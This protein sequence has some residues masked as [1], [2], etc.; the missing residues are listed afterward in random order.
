MTQVKECGKC[1]KSLSVEFHLL[2]L[3]YNNCIITLQSLAHSL[4]SKPVCIRN[5]ESE[6]PAT[7]IMVILTIIAGGN[8][9]SHAAQFKMFHGF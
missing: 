2:F 5:E 7:V 1:G 8:L 9:L 6:A 3:Q 4:F